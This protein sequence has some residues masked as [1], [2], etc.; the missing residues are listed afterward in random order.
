MD[1]ILSGRITALIHH[2]GY[3]GKLWPR[4]AGGSLD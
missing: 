1:F 2:A 4:T 3:S